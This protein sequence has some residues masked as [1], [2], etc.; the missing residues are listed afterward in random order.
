MYTL[1]FI[2]EFIDIFKILFYAFLTF[3][4]MPYDPNH[5][6]QLFIPY[7]LAIGPLAHHTQWS[8]KE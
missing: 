4:Y 7:S 6:L 1:K 2:L 5:R 8:E 3:F